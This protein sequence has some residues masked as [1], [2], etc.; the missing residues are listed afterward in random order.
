MGGGRGG[1]DPGQVR[2]GVGEYGELG[3]RRPGAGVGLEPDG[4][5]V[6]FGDAAQHRARVDVVG[7]QPGGGGE[8]SGAEVADGELA[9]LT[10]QHGR[11]QGR[12][13]DVEER[14]PVGLQDG[15][16]GVQPA[17]G[18]RGQPGRHEGHEVA[19]A[20]QQGG[21]LG[22]RALQV[23]L[24]GRAQD[25]GSRGVPVGGRQHQIGTGD[26]DGGRHANPPVHPVRGGRSPGRHVR[27]RTPG[28]MRGTARPQTPAR[29][30]PCSSTISA[31]PLAGQGLGDSR[32]RSTCH[33]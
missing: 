4:D 7:Q 6:E 24:A 5:P 19:V 31:S 28:R 29:L 9:Q 33:R 25:G 18:G 13:V 1:A 22:E 32:A 2:L 26:S 15:P 14:D 17:D 16:Y 10:G 8:H 21:G 11:A 12:E 3:A 27:A 30:P 23:G 20:L